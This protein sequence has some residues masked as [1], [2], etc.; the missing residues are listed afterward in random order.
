MAYKLHTEL[1]NSKIDNNILFS[2]FV[3]SSKT[4][5]NAHKL[6]RE[7]IINEIYETLYTFCLTKA[8]L[9]SISREILSGIQAIFQ[10]LDENRHKFIDS[11]DLRLFL[12]AEKI[13]HKEKDINILMNHFGNGEKIT[14]NSFKEV[15]G[16][17]I[18]S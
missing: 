18:N 7:E 16:I 11:T 3:C 1:Q 2:L 4:T 12:K 8:T 13:T 14:Y 10:E 15:F 9:K 5:N 6:S 17:Q